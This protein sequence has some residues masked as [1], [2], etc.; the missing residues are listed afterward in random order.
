VHNAQKSDNAFSLLLA[1][2]KNDKI[3]IVPY[4]AVLCFFTFNVTNISLVDK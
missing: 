4:Y 3:Y 2:I 1:N